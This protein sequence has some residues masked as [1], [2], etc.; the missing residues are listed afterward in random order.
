MKDE[1]R[2]NVEIF[3]YDTG[4]V[5][6]I[7]GKNMTEKKAEERQMRGLMRCNSDFGCRVVEVKL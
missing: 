2:Y 5:S 3:K 6:S 4:K 7:I 1:K